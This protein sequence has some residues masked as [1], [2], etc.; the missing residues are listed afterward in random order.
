MNYRVASFLIKHLVY[1]KLGCF[2]KKLKIICDILSLWINVFWISVVWVVKTTFFSSLNAPEIEG[3]VRH[4]WGFAHHAFFL[5]K[6]WRGKDMWLSFS[7]QND[8]FLCVYSLC[9]GLSALWMVAG[10]WVNFIIFNPPENRNWVF[11]CGET[12][13]YFF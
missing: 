10:T 11:K 7:R 12:K 5:L 6:M 13:R 1:W 2:Q 3:C 9:I 4:F 8:V